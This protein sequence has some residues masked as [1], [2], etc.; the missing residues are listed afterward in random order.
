[1]DPGIENTHEIHLPLSKRGARRVIQRAV[2]LMGRDKALRQKLRSVELTTR[3]LIED[4]GSE[5]TVIVDQGHIAF[6]RGHVG[7]PQVKFLWTTGDAFL[8][9]LEPKSTPAEGFKLECEPALRRVVDM[10]FQPFLT[11][12]RNVLADPVDDDGVRLV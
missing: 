5:W 10:L 11:T 8:S 3:W 2:V 1:M 12:L 6:H 4:W 9:H 7:K